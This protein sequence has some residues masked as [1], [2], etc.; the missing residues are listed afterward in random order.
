MARSSGRSTPYPDHRATLTAQAIDDWF[1][2]E[3]AAAKI[4]LA[5]Q[6]VCLNSADAS[7]RPLGELVLV[8]RAIFHTLVEPR[9][10]VPKG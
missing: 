2:H 1:W 6:R 5:L 4:F 10:T 3:T 8:P 7:L 9:Q